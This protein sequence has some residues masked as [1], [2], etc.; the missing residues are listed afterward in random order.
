[1]LR[2]CLVK[3]GTVLGGDVFLVAAPGT[4]TGYT[5]D[6]SQ[7]YQIRLNASAVAGLHAALTF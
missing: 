2:P 1:M 5:L 7:Q 6:Y 3:A 4:L